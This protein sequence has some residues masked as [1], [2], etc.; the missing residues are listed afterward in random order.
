MHSQS[1]RSFVRPFARSSPA[2]ERCARA[3][4]KASGYAFIGTNIAVSAKTN[5]RATHFVAIATAV[6][7]EYEW[8]KGV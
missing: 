3:A 4:A 5:T 6:I 2:L 7:A 1:A 8:E